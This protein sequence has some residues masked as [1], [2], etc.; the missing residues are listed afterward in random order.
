MRGS[1]FRGVTRLDFTYGSHGTHKIVKWYYILYN[2][3]THPSTYTAK[4]HFFLPPFPY[5][6]SPVPTSHTVHPT[7]ASPPPRRYITCTTPNIDAFTPTLHPLFPHHLNPTPISPPPHPYITS[8]PPLH[9]LDPT[10]TSPPPH[11][12]ITSSPPLHH[13]HPYIS[14]HSPLHH[15]PSALTSPPPCPLH[16]LHPTPISPPP[17]TSSIIHPYIISTLSLYPL[18]PVP[19]I[20]SITPYIPSLTPIKTSASALASSVCGR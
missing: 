17:P 4:H 10:P 20:T 16:H 15:L 2:I 3:C 13:L 5:V 18:H 19:Y 9:H 12:Y 1:P 7:P 11:P 8:T 14:Y 6:P